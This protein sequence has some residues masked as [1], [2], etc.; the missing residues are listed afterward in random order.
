[1]EVHDEPSKALSDGNTVLDIKY[2]E[3]ILA[4]AKTAHEMRLDL[5]DQW[6][7][8]RVHLEE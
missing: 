1:M 6:G 2:L 4:H 3:R 5:L 7:I 8:D